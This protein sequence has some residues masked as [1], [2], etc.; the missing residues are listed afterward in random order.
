MFPR[1][2]CGFR[3][4]WLVRLS[5]LQRQRLGPDLLQVGDEFALAD[6]LVV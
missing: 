5:W 6:I 1:C 2:E 4:L 3:G